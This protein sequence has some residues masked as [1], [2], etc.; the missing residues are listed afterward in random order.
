MRRFTLFLFVALATTSVNAAS[1]QKTDGTVFDPI[2]AMQDGALVYSDYSGPNLEPDANLKNVV[3]TNAFLWHADLTNAN[4]SGANLFSAFLLEADLSYADLSDANLSWAGVGSTNLSYANL[5]DA[6][7]TQAILGDASLDH[8]NV[9]GATFTGAEHW[10]SAKWTDAFYYTDNV[11]AWASG[12]DPVALGILALA[13]I[14][15]PATLLL[16]LLALTAVPLRVRC[17]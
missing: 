3:L 7:L 16:A 8:A 5:T 9:S 4:L 13:P 6:D 2:Q 10:T 12:M 17:G 15:E 14:P 11:P 1:Y